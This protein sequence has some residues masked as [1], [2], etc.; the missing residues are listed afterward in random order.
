MEIKGVI[1]YNYHTHTSRCG[2]AIG[3]EEEYILRAIDCGIKYMGFSDHAPLMFDDGTQSG[4]RVPVEKTQD[5][6]T[7]IIALEKKYA[8]K[9]D[10]SIGFES[11]YY[12]KYIDRMVEAAASNGVEYFILG[13]HFIAPE[14][15]PGSV[16]MNAPTEDR[17]LLR[18]Y[19]KSLADAIENGVFTYIAHPDMI[20]FVGE[21][22]VF[23]D[24]MKV[25]CEASKAYG[26]PLEINCLGIRDNRNYPTRN[27]FQLMG[28][29]QCPVTMGF[30]AHDI[31]NA[32]DGVSAQKALDY[33]KEY[34]MNYIGRPSLVKLS[35]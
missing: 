25:V 27:M 12:P 28:E 5:Y 32:Y 18:A 14:N 7:T 31:E 4:Y 34:G 1:D 19:A 9:I 21:D 33:V 8:D 20:R 26:V 24:E 22:K 3:T 6:V 35:K 16:H 10:I 15:E 23:M 11:E 13:Q 29:T 17:L 2:H 30:D